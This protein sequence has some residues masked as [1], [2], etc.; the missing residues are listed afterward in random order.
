MFPMF[1]DAVQLRL[2]PLLKVM[3]TGCELLVAALLTAKFKTLRLR[4][5]DSLIVVVS[6]KTKV[7]PPPD[8]VTWLYWV[9]V[10]VGE[11]YTFPA[12]TGKLGRG[13]QASL[14]LNYH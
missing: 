3:P 12:I 9:E 7:G 10:A 5:K 2:A 13:F 4:D 6:V 1:E 8:T 11:T 14:R